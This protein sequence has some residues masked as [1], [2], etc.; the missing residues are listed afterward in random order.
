MLSIAFGVSASMIIP[1]N[2]NAKEKAEAPLHSPVIDEMWGL[3]RVDF[4]H[5]ANGGV[6]P[7]KPGADACYKLMGVK[8]TAFPVSYAIN[9]INPYIE[10]ESFVLGAISSSAETWDSV[11]SRELFNGAYALDY[12]AVYG[13]QDYKNSIVFGAYSDNNAIAVTSVWFT[14]V[15]KRIVE[16]DMLFNNYYAWGDATLDASK[17]DLQN[18]ATHEFG[19]SVGMD[20]IYSSAC[21]T[22]TMFG[23]SNYGE[24]SK[25]TL[26]GADI[27]GLQK[28]YGA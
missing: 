21:S 17:M 7:A 16:F 11:T 22:V 28:M 6:R 19:H 4:V 1:A 5:Y 20:D 10:N 2:E 3:E 12:A 9:P 23:Y 13:V 27:T 26:E 14:R 8:W 18:I 15:G 24:I 25:R